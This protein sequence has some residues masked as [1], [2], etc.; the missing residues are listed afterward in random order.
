VSHATDAED[1]HLNESSQGRRG[2]SLSY[3]VTNRST[4][5]AV[6]SVAAHHSSGGKGLAALE[7]LRGLTVEL[8]K[9]TVD[10]PCF[11]NV[12]IKIR[13]ALSDSDMA[14]ET[15]AR[16]IGA[17]PRLSARLLQMANSAAVN[18]SG[19]RITELKSAITRLGH[20]M[21]QSATIAY[22]VQQLKEAPSLSEIA[23]PLTVL[24]K[25]SITTASICQ[26]VA[27]RTHIPPDEAFLAGLLHGIGRLY[28]MVRAVGYD[29]GSVESGSLAELIADWH[30]IIG[31]MVLTNWD[32]DSSVTEAVK[33]QHI[34]T[35]PKRA[36]AV[37]TD[38]LVVAIMLADVIVT[39]SKRGAEIEENPSFRLIGLKAEDCGLIMTHASYQLD[40]LLEALGC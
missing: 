6:P 7:F 38:V 27:R 23:A 31:Q 26:V 2:S 37:L 33:D 10:L 9:G 29:T 39:G 18:P 11:P 17:E 21:V 32:M 13:E 40:S 8:S 28:I 3:P 20:Q 25:R 30:P 22:A 16:M 34:T 36:E 24:W 35:L 12:V 19:K 1:L 5:K 4:S 15:I 14:V